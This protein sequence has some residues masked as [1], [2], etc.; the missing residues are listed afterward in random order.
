MNS[1]ASRSI[2]RKTVLFSTILVTLLVISATT[3]VPQS[4]GKVV[5]DQLGRYEVYQQFNSLLE[6]LS[7]EGT[8]IAS[9]KIC[10]LLLSISNIL[11]DAISDPTNLE[12][13]NIQEI[14]SDSSI[15]E[16]ISEENLVAET[17]K[18][19]LSLQTALDELQDSNTI[20]GEQKL[21]ISFWQTLLSWL[22]QLLKNKLTGGD[23]NSG[24]PDGGN[25]GFF[26]T[27]LSILSAIMV[28]PIMIL[29]VL[30]KG[31]VGVIGGILKILGSIVV[32]FLLFLAGT[33]TTL[34][35]GA[36]F[37]IFLGLMSKIGIQAFSIIGAPIFA[38]IAAQLSVSTGSLLGGLSM[39]LFSVLGIIILLAL[40]LAI[41]ALIFLAG[42]DSSGS[43]DFNFNLDFMGNGTLYMI[44]SIIASWIGS[45]NTE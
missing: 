29:K 16:P 27:L 12:D 4:Q 41:I 44:L 14:M 3:V 22:F 43:P 6:T 45:G 9:S 25:G 15:T 11:I 1:F 24:T 8:D 40:P 10:S 33:Q 18:T 36:F 13:L 37:L 32:I 38:I 28:I 42:G 19:I 23:T 21:N 31:L 34:T 30:V 17:E 7:M 39:A 2:K 20:P 5:N 35:L 26:E